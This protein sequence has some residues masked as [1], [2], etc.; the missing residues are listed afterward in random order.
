M[1][2][3][4]YELWQECNNK[5][6][7]C[8][9]HYLSN[10]QS[11][12]FKIESM[13]GV[14]NAIK[15]DDFFEKYDTI[16]FIGGEF[17]QGQMDDPDVEAKFFEMMGI[18]KEKA[19]EK[20]LRSIWMCATLTIG[21]QHHLYK[22]L[23]MFKDVNLP[24]YFWVLTSYD[25]VGR[26]HT[27]QLWHNWEN[28]MWKIRDEYPKIKVNT[29]M[30]LTGALIDKYLADNEF[31]NNFLKDYNTTL[32]IKSPTAVVFDDEGNRVPKTMQYR[33]DYNRDVIPNWFPTRRQARDFFYTLYEKNPELYDNVLN[34]HFRSDIL[35]RNYE[36]HES[37]YE[38]RHKDKKRESDYGTVIE[39]GHMENYR[40]YV[41]AED[42]CLLCDKE[43]IKDALFQ[44]E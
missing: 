31:F 19:L 28:N 40:V 14:I 3:F 13:Q 5:C 20:K 42:G 36:G 24:E 4:Q 11:K 2:C 17:F 25:P 27:D 33:Q 26:F 30:V 22:L 32:F 43:A 37:T 15:E 10:P 44:G 7:Y 38:E 16:G 41:D 6:T 29:C 12:E 23:D 18:L 35:I 9:N 34:I 21:D 39:C 8:Y 1:K